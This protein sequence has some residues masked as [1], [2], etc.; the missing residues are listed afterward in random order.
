MDGSATAKPRV[1]F[2]HFGVYVTDI[3][4]MEK[5]YT[6][7][8]G[9]TVTDRGTLGGRRIVFLSSDPFE[10]HQLVLA[11]GKPAGL[12]FNA[13]N[14]I[15]FR[16]DSLA[17]LRDLHRRLPA[18]P[19]SEIYTVNHGIAWSVYFHDP[20]GHR[21]EL[22]VDTPWFVDQPLREP[23]DLT[24]SDAEILQATEAL[25]RRLPGFQPYGDWRR[26]I[27]RKMGVELV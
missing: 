9:L 19:V 15:S 8:V 24:T 16:L 23:L 13:I 27:A 12:A 10:H 7:F 25:C 20:E 22:F 11:D 5:F 2:S 6:D 18:Q 1:R 3:D 4:A 26:G 21:V 14:Q 17:V